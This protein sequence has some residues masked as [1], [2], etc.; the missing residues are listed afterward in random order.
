MAFDIAWSVGDDEWERTREL[1]AAD[2]DSDYDRFDLPLIYFC[3]GTVRFLIDGRIGRPVSISSTAW[4]EFSAN[5]RRGYQ[6]TAPP[7]RTDFRTGYDLSLLDLA[8][9]FIAVPGEIPLEAASGDWWYYQFDDALIFRF[10]W[11]HD[12]AFVLSSAWRDRGWMLVTTLDHFQEGVQ[13]SLE[14]LGHAIHEQVPGLG[15]WETLEPIRA[16]VR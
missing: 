2:P 12:R 1:A 9:Q 10:H 11:E 8:V 6:S 5:A 16:F 13:R 14:E 15:E 4:E 3:R 7:E